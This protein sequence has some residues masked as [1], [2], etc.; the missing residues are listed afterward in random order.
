MGFAA[1]G[2]SQMMILILAAGGVG[3]PL[4]M[5]PEKEDPNLA[6]VAPEQ[7]LLYAT[8]S[9]M[10]KA[11]PAS[12]N[13]TEQLLAEPELARFAKALEDS[14]AKVT[15]QLGQSEDPRIK[16]AAAMVPIWSR[17]ILTRPTAIFVTKLVPRENS[18]E[19]EAGLIV[20][21]DANAA[22]LAQSL[23]GLLA[24][25]DGEE[26]RLKEVTI[27]GKKFYQL[28]ADPQAVPV[29]LVFGADGD[30]F[31][32]SLGEG[33]IEGM[34]TRVA[35]RKVPAWLTKV[36]NDLPVERRASLSYV[37]VKT[38]RETLLPL[39]GPQAEQIAAG[40][41]LNQVQTLQTVAGLDADGIV[42]RSLVSI[43]G[44]SRGIL[45]LLDGPGI[46][47]AQLGHIPSDALFASAFSL[48]AAKAFDTTD[49]LVRE[50]GGAFA[51]RQWD[52]ALRQMDD[53]SGVK[54]KDDVLA[55]LGS[56]WTI[57]MGAA[58]GWY[59]GLVATVEVK[60]RAKLATVQEKLVALTRREGEEF[61]P[62]SVEIKTTEHDGQQIHHLSIGGGFLPVQPAWCITDKQLI[63]ALYPQTVRSIL[64]RPQSDK[65]LADAPAVTAAMQGE[66]S[67]V[68]VTYQDS[69]RMFESSYPYLQM[70]LPMMQQG[71]NEGFREFGGG[72]RPPQLFDGAMLPASRS[73]HRHLQPGVT[74]VRRT[75]R[76][77]ETTTR[78]TLPTANVGAT[79]PVAVALLLPA[80]Q[81][82][83]ESARRMQ[84]QNNLKQ[85]GLAMH[86]YHD[87]WKR[88]PASHTLTADGKPKL[89]WRV[90][91]LPYIEQQQLY[92]QFHL[93][94]PWDSEHNKTLIAKIPPTYRSPTTR[95]G[96]G[97]TT[98][99]GAKGKNAAFVDPDATDKGKDQAA[100]ISLAAVVDGTSNTIMIVEASDDKAVAWTKPG[101][102]EPDPME[103]L[104]GLIGPSG[105]GFNAC[106]CDG[107]VRM[108]KKSIDPKTLQRL[109]Q[110]NDGEPV[111]IPE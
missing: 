16:Q 19:I 58:D 64:S 15:E 14:L 45:T 43:D 55:S 9:G 93:D 73:I 40:L 39:A 12:K 18:A 84:S 36:Q 109:F 21:A 4:G 53:A 11:D 104:K 32:L 24:A 100:G 78:Q 23:A 20:K 38:L 88:F 29:P 92:E 85:L 41:G 60:D 101:D 72:G 89:S 59:T 69:R 26:K 107:A 44:K 42:S 103:P 62:E 49:G 31:F 82:A 95:S 80:V 66:G 17:A 3:L 76:G 33:V 106:F 90:H 70:F 28:A 22:K 99:L 54:L 81:A 97:M 51:A 34:R 50:L 102:F 63:V 91:M 74:V 47:P 87:V 98:Y 10:A 67:I 25:G 68:A 48:D 6:F 2:M 27:G 30:Y 71:M 35:A 111:E 61:G 46:K 5:P 108:I 96:E 77:L 1:M 13:H 94:E 79:A 110:R 83:R 8:W 65:S 7:C 52:E 86:N 57:S 37:N 75:P 105:Q 56:T